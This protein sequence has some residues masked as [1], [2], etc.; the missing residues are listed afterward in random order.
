M[1][2]A[3][4]TKSL[5]AKPLAEMNQ[6]LHMHTRLVSIIAL[7][8]AVTACS[9][10]PTRNAALDQAES[11]FNAAQADPQVV[12]LASDE[13]RSARESLTLAEQSQA[14]GKPLATID[15]LAYMSSQRV[16]IAQ[17]T[18]SSR[19]AQEV[20]AGAAAERNKARL[21]ERT[22]EANTANQRL[23]ARTQEVDNANL[24]LAARTAEADNANLKLA[25]SQESEARKT[26]ALAAAD[27]SALDAAELNRARLAERSNETDDAN[28]KLAV[29]QESEARKTAAL[30][31]AEASALT[32]RDLKARSDARTSDLEDQLR[33]LNA[34]KTERGMVLTLGDV[35]FASGQARLV[36]DSGRNMGKVA[37]FMIRNPMQRAA[38]D[39]YTDSVG[40]ASANYGL[41]QRRASAVMDA[42]VSLGVPANHLSMRPHGAD[43]PVASNDT[44]EG[45]QL[46]RRVE[47]VFSPAA[48]AV[49]TN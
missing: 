27:N 23:A 30:A 34:K 29:S 8:A 25:A 18:A 37:D 38:I 4:S 32:A 20:T 42:L 15:H 10:V 19:L 36:S 16:A 31:A 40:S 5:R 35:L 46:N 14:A 6:D 24:R 9:S 13:M 12:R 33:A 49:S 21:A 39:G 47:I 3:H 28:R 1:P 48:E 43:M 7:A 11:R 17:L 44:A 26:A 45:R 22:A 2:L 41:S